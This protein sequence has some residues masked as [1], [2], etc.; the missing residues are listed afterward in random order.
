MPISALFRLFRFVS[1]LVLTAM[2]AQAAFPRITSY[3]PVRGAPGTVVTITGQN[4]SGLTDVLFGNTKAAVQTASASQLRVIVPGDALSG[5][6]SVYTTGG[7]DSTQLLTIPNF[8]VAPRIT[9]FYREFGPDGEPVIPAKALTGDRIYIRGANFDDPNRPADPDYGLAVFVNGVRAT[10][11]AVT[12]PANIQFIVP[13]GAG[14]GPITI[15]NFAGSVVSA[16]LLYFQPVITAYTARAASG[17]TINIYGNNFTGVSSVR[18]GALDAASFT[19]KSATNIQAV[20]PANAVNGAIGITAPGGAF[21]TTTAFQVLPLITGFTPA[22]GDV[23]TVVTINGSALT[24]TTSVRFGGVSTLLFTNLSATQITAR[25]PSGAASGPISVVTANGTNSSTATF[26]L[27]PAIL[28]FNPV[29]GPPGTVVRITGR[30]LTETTALALGTNSVPNFTVDSN[31]QITFT[32][33]PGLKTGTLA[34]SGPGGS[35]ES[36]TTFRVTGNEPTITGFSPNFG[37]IG[38]QVT[39][40]GAR[41]ASVTNVTFGG[42]KAVFSVP[43][44]TDL[45]AL[46]PAGAVTGRITVTSAD[47]STTSASDFYLGTN[48]DLRTTLTVNENPPVA[49]GPLTCVWRLTNLGPVPST[50]TIGKLVLPAGLTYFDATV[51]RPF[52]LT[53]N[54][55]QLTAGVLEPGETIILSLR[56]LVG[57][58]G[59]ISLQASVTNRITDNNLGNNSV[60]LPLN[61]QPPRLFIE[62]L[63]SGQLLLTWSAAGTNYVAERQT[64]LG[65]ATWETVSGNPGN[66]GATLQLTIPVTQEREYLR[67]RPHGSP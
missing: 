9:D 12:S 37:A 16:Q 13:A 14:T 10:Q 40:T 17:D 63:P 50:N 23:G 51:N 38:T 15:T 49:Y 35:A 20:V 36:S 56:T 31:T 39:V 2:A 52:T 5:P 3:T 24:G 43:N 25:V 7:Q 59:L 66:D 46:V 41:L 8:Q 53:G 30:N 11:G 6:I 58:P 19:V 32:V 27:A 55:L 57:A 28:S 42:V 47:G 34:V 26:Y 54:E 4:F 45:V 1:L 18:I 22:N 33:P 29:Q 21:I 44:G 67:L 48:A 65:G 62:P 60:T 64:E 61:A